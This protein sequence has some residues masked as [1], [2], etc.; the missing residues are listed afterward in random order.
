VLG[1][2]GRNA[3]VTHFAVTGTA[4]MGISCRGEGQRVHKAMLCQEL[5]NN[6]NQT[7]SEG[8]RSTAWPENA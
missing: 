3:K 7:G 2:E 5:L 4:N 8:A 6:P 1:V